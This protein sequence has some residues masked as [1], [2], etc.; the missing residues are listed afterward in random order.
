M[1]LQL[2]GCL[3]L[4]SCRFR[5]VRA[6]P[7]FGLVFLP[8][9]PIVVVAR[10]APVLVGVVVAHPTPHLVGVML[11]LAFSAPP[12]VVLVLARLDPVLLVCQVLLNACLQGP[13]RGN[14]RAR[15]VRVVSRLFSLEGVRRRQMAVLRSE[16]GHV[17]W[18]PQGEEELPAASSLK[19]H[20]PCGRAPHEH[21]TSAEAP[22]VLAL[23]T[24]PVDRRTRPCRRVQLEAFCVYPGAKS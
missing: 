18:F 22:T 20:V 3:H 7:A 24:E 12:L 21:G 16:Y 10:P 5:L 19:L 2:D 23:C 13:E 4:T 8:S 17:I 6:R 11:V 14:V 1:R 15:F 9:L